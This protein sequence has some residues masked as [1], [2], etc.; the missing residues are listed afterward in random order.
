MKVFCPYCKSEAVLKDAFHIYRRIDCGFVY[1]CEKNAC[2]AYVAADAKS[3]KPKGS[4]ANSDLRQ[5]R[6]QVSEAL[7]AIWSDR[8]LVERSEVYVAAAQVLKTESFS[9]YSIREELAKFFLENKVSIIFDIKVQIQRNRLINLSFV[10]SGLLLTLHHLFV[11]SKRSIHHVLPHNFN[12]GYLESF[13]NAIKAGL[14][15]KFKKINTEKV[16]YA[17]TP[18]G[19]SAIGIENA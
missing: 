7:S 12:K 6:Y 2:D 14:V 5:L 17:L 9:V 1:L 4:L 3:H 13:K 16:F 19:C 10:D 15:R 18:A 11:K 8:L